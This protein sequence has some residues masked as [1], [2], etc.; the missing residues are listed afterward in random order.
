MA[1]DYYEILGLDR[2]ATDEDIKRAFRKLAIKYHP[3]KNP[4]DKVAEEKFKEINEAYQ[5]LSDPQKRAQYDQ[6]GTADFNGQGGF[7]GFEGFSG[8]FG[9]FGGFTDIFGDIFGD[10]F[11]GGRRAKNGPQ[12]GADLEYT[13]DLTFEEAAFGVKKD[14]DIFRYETCDTCSGSGAKP[15]T[16]PKTCDRCH[17][18]GQVRT[19]RNTPFGS[20]VSVTTCDRCRGE[21]KIIE[22]PCPSCL[23]SG[24]VRKKKIVSINIPAGVD[25]GN[26]IPLRGEGEPGVRGGAPGD[27]YI[28]IR[29]KPHKIFKRQGFDILCE[30]PISFIKAS[31]GGEIIIPTL[32]GDVK[33]TISEGTQPGTV[34]KL[35]GKGIPRI[36]GN[37]RGDLLAEL[38]I[39]IPK[40]LNEKQRD[41]LRKLAIEFGED[42]VE[43]KK[44]FMDKVKD[45]FGGQ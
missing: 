29:V 20:F 25:T 45:A 35:R 28:N 22:T 41:L 30:V 12:R 15:G 19:Q 27:L 7:G 8:G 42:K 24:R 6:F 31:L 37:G 3:D 18:T 33:Q 39:E 44:S 5:V 17:G 34:I 1:K 2:N 13:L 43:G 40:R 21:G 38:K 23:G 4:G 11:G 10:M 16:S 26:T 14:I 9:G 36:R 32:E